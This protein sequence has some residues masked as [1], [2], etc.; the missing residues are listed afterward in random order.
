ME[1]NI[2]C[3]LCK[4]CVEM[5]SRKRQTYQNKAKICVLFVFDLDGQC[6]LIENKTL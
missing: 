5:A 1:D 2:R 3:I 4:V 6:K